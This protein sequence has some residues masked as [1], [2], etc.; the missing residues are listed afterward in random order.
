MSKNK[1]IEFKYY[2]KIDG[3]SKFDDLVI[4]KGPLKYV[5][6]SGYDHFFYNKNDS[7]AF[8]RFR[9]GQDKE[10]SLKRKEP[11]KDNNVV[12]TE[13]NIPL[14]RFLVSEDV[15]TYCEEL[16]YKYTGSIFKNCFI[17][18]F[19]D[20]TLSYYVCYD[21]NMREMGRFIEIE[22]SNVGSDENCLHD[23]IVL[24]KVWK[25]LNISPASRVK[26]S[27]FELYGK[28]EL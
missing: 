18:N 12:R 15:F 27:L 8:I 25:C 28:V 9:D 10:L 24:E 14:E 19:L 7:S 16:G 23:L 21:N 20:Y 22:V 17:Y 5:Q 26:E 11:G 6:A 13:I 4:S 1:E 2:A 3:L